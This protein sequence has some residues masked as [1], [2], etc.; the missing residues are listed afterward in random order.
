VEAE[1]DRTGVYLPGGRQAKQEGLALR[2]H[3][4]C[5]RSVATASR[6]RKNPAF[7]AAF[8]NG[9][10]SLRKAVFDTSLL[11]GRLPRAGG[12]VRTIVE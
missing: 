5:A 12:V 7:R 4:H 3:Q 2:S 10:P 1:G 11:W 6:P 8:G 9:S